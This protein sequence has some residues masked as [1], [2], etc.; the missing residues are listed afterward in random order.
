M[1]NLTV[2]EI[3]DLAAF[4]GLKIDTAIPAAD[5][6]QET[7]ITVAACPPEG[8]KNE[9]EP[10]DPDSVSHYRFIAYCTEYPEEGCMGLGNEL[11]PNVS[12]EGTANPPRV[13]R[14]LHRLVL[15]SGLHISGQPEDE[16][17]V[18]S[19][20]LSRLQ[21]QRCLQHPRFPAR[22]LQRRP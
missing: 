19:R 1:L 3:R 6:E 20:R 18:W 7:E 16:T 5:D 11:P 17:Q 10:S 13:S 8:V 4:A 12:G 14:T 22:M 9:A 21:W 15:F 2:A